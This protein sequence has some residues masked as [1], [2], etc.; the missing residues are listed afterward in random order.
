MKSFVFKVRR[1]PAGW[2]VEDHF[3]SGP[4]VAKDH[5]LNLAEGMALALRQQ[6]QDAS[7]VV[8]DDIGSQTPVT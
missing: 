2:V 4:F 3:T 6:G 1:V 5:A 8:I 7:V